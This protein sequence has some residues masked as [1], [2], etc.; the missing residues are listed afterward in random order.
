[1]K[2]LPSGSLARLRQPPPDPAR[3]GTIALPW[4]NEALKSATQQVHRQLMRDCRDLLEETVLDGEAQRQV[5]IRIRTY[6]AKYTDLLPNGAEFENIAQQI[7]DHLAGLGPVQRLLDAPDI[8]EIMVNSATDIWVEVRGR[9]HR[10]HDIR[11]RDDQHVFQVCQRVLAPLGIEFSR[12]RPL[13]R[14][15]LP[16]GVRVAASM[17][18]LDTCV[19]LNLRK[20]TMPE[21]SVAD[22]VQLGTASEDM[23]EFLGRCL[24]GRLNVLICGPTGSGKSTLLRLLSRWYPEGS[25]VMVLEHISELELGRLHHHVKTLEARTDPLGPSRIGLHT[26]LEHCLHRLPEFL[27]V[28]EVLGEEALTMLM[29]MATGHPV[30]ATAHADSAERLFSR[31]SLAM[32]QARLEINNDQLLRELAQHLDIVAFISRSPDGVRRLMSIDQVVGYSDG[33]PVLHNLFRYELDSERDAAAAAPVAEVADGTAPYGG[34]AEPS[35]QCS[36]QQGDQSGAKPSDPSSAKPIDQNGSNL[37]D[38]SAANPSGHG[39]NLGDN[40]LAIAELLGPPMASLSVGI[41]LDEASAGPAPL[42]GRFVRTGAP[43]EQLRA[44]AGRWGVQL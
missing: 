9:L 12:A 29:A 35:D 21:P 42:V 7:F 19:S 4:K 6:L 38:P 44:K 15:R 8:T 34:G 27:V 26:L 20:N 23:L 17:P 37:G 13:A 14:G 36:A 1:M 32:L 24:A 16:S 31:L 43:T 41:E 30:M 18:P 28:G 33:Q 22:F 3:N 2:S 39:A 40:E 25:R 11:F 5:A 10:C